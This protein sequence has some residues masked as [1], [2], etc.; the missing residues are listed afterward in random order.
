MLGSRVAPV[1]LVAIAST[2]V[3]LQ[4]KIARIDA[5]VQPWPQQVVDQQEQAV[6]DV[7]A[8][9]AERTGLIDVCTAKVASDLG[10]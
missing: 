2:C 7:A 1:R 10:K 4:S 9:I 5:G 8:R 6:M 3:V